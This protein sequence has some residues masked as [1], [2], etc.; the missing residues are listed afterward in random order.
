MGGGCFFLF[1]PLQII[2]SPK[3]IPQGHPNKFRDRRPGSNGLEKSSY[4]E[5]AM[6]RNARTPNPISASG[7]KVFTPR[8]PSSK[9]FSL[10]P[11]PSR[12]RTARTQFRDK[13]SLN[14][15]TWY[16]AD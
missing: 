14:T 1:Q 2:S 4:M 5:A 15:L 16:Q 11:A 9:I 10:P 3:I 13:T 12:Y 6:T 7:V 8:V